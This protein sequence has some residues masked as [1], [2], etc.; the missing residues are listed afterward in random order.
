MKNDNTTGC[1]I[2]G[3]GPCR[4]PVQGSYQLC[5]Y[6]GSVCPI[7]WAVAGEKQRVALAKGEWR[8]KE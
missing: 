1:R 2:L 6:P 8:E 4:Y 3:H 7:Y 5:A